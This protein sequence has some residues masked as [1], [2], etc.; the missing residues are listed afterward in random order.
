VANTTKRRIFISYQRQHEGT[1]SELVSLLEAEPHYTVWWDRKMGGGKWWDQIIKHIEWADVVILALSQSYFVSEACRRELQHAQAT[2]RAIVPI[3]VDA[4]L[5]YADIP[6]DLVQEQIEK[7]AGQAIQYN[8]L[9]NLL[10]TVT[11]R[12]L[13]EPLPEPPPVPI[14]APSP[15]PA[16]SN[17]VL[18]VG[19]VLTVLVILAL[20]GVLLVGSGDEDNPDA[21]TPAAPLINA[22]TTDTDV[23]N[24]T[25]ATPDNETATENTVSAGEPG[26]FD[27]DVI[28]GGDESL[29][30][31]IN[32]ISNLNGVELRTFAPEHT[33]VLTEDFDILQAT[34]G[35]IES[36]ICLIYELVDADPRRPLACSE[37]QNFTVP[38][39]AGNIFWFDRI[40]NGFADIAVYQ[41]DEL[42][43]ICTSQSGSG[44]CNITAP[45]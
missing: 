38:L 34:G 12:P 19:G 1:V 24:A 30:I 4:K 44:I 43:D 45:Q 17:R 11:L 29:H 22:D 28:Y 2:H 36:G 35:E 8:K 23:E 33:A 13:P 14:D 5:D 7:Y 10:D 42:A 9:K 20:I 16:A 18:L 39:Q 32:G 37:T 25:E 31:A 15:E 41:A 6:P 40:S 3:I 27:I 26:P 21:T